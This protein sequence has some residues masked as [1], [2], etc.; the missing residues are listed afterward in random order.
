MEENKVDMPTV[1]MP[2]DV[3]LLSEAFDCAWNSLR[4]SYTDENCETALR[5]RILLANSI[6]RARKAGEHEVASLVAAGIRSID[7]P[8]VG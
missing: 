8:L 6:L 7:T 4:A 5:A 1:L 3:A 2:E